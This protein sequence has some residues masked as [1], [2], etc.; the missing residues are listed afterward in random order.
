MKPFSIE[1]YLANPCKVVD[2]GGNEV[3]VESKPL[4]W[5]NAHTLYFAD[6]L[7]E[8]SYFEKKLYDILTL[9]LRLPESEVET[10]EYVKKCADELMEIVNEQ[11]Y[12]NWCR[13]NDVGYADG[14]ADAMMGIP[15]WKLATEDLFGNDFLVKHMEKAMGADGNTYYEI[16]I[17]PEPL[18]RK[19][20]Y[21]V[22]MEELECLPTEDAETGL[23]KEYVPF[24]RPNSW[25][26]KELKK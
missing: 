14:K 13:G 3:D 4:H 21:Y 5:L 17:C 12:D 2:K 6:P 18:V 22:R 26:P 1:E 10:I 16:D 24:V 15:K 25:P 20:E 19:G 11:L 7:P 23:L 8:M 9:N